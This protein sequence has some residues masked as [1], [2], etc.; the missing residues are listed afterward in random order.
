MALYVGRLAPE[1]N[2]PLV[3]RAYAAMKAERP[4]VRLVLVGEVQDEKKY[5]EAALQEELRR[6]NIDICAS[7]SDAGTGATV[8]NPTIP[9]STSATNASSRSR[10]RRASP[11][12]A[13]ND[14]SS[15]AA[16]STSMI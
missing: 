11:R 3:M 9:P 7:L 14:S 8:A 4:E 1:K 15:N 16:G 2:L 6:S 13:V 10:A 5:G 12:H